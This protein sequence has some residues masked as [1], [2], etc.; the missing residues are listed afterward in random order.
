MV[1]AVQRGH[2]L[3]ALLIACALGMASVMLALR[4]ALAVRLDLGEMAG[5]VAILQQ[6]LYLALTAQRPGGMPDRLG[7]AGHP[8]PRA[9]RW[10]LVRT[11]SPDRAGRVSSIALETGPPL[12]PGTGFWLASCRKAEWMAPP[13]HWQ[14]LQLDGLALEGH[15]WPSLVLV[16]AP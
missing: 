5:R 9:G 8:G 15:H 3:A 12:P 14:G 6:Q 7:C 16:R 13:Q 11:G 10:Q 1:S 2:V 4:I